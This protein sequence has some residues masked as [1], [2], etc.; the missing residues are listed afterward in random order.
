MLFSLLAGLLLP[1]LLPAPFLVW[2]RRRPFWPCSL[3]PTRSKPGSLIDTVDAGIDDLQ[4]FIHTGVNINKTL[5]DHNISAPT[6]WAF[7]NKAAS[8]VPFPH[9]ISRKCSQYLLLYGQPS[10]RVGKRSAP[11]H[12][13][14]TTHRN[15]LGKWKCEECGPHT[16]AVSNDTTAFLGPKAERG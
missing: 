1:S 5:H 13:R 12:L 4:F 15:P 9:G 3:F 10:A 11:R 16:I 2:R 14:L 7:N 8:L 6:S